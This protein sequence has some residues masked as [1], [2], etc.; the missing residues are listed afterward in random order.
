MNR[1]GLLALVHLA[2]KQLALDEDTYRLALEQVTGKSSA[3]ELSD[4]ELGRVVDHFRT[5]GWAPKPKG[6]SA[7][8]PRPSD[9][10]HVR[11]VWAIWGEM[12]K[13]GTV[14]NPTR[15]ALRAFVERMT[16]VTDPEWL[17]PAQANVVVEGLKAWRERESRS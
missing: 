1:R 7:P 13:A 9:N 6:K 15:A 3:A 8:R 16:G 2:R 11:K 12:C 4:G 17:S 10:R 14:R 5:K